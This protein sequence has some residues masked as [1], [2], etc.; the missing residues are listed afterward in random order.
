MNKIYRHLF[1]KK[2]RENININTEKTIDIFDFRLNLWINHN[3]QIKN[4]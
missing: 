2:C 3:Y 4:I 1:L